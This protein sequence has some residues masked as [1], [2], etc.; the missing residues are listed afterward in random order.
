MPFCTA[1]AV[2]RG[3]VGLETFEA[4]LIGDPAILAM[5]ERVTMRVDPSLDASAPALT[6]ARVTVRLRDG[7]VLT[8]CANGAR[9]YHERP[10]SEAELATKFCRARGRRCRR[11]RPARRSRRCAGLK[12]IADVRIVTARLSIRLRRPVPLG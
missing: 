10:A 6:Q 3:S 12:S 4:A 8:A 7:R 1:A 11:A 2:V 5:Q 9:G